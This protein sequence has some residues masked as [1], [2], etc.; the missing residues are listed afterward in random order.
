VARDVPARIK[1]AWLPQLGI[2]VFPRDLTQI[3][4]RLF[5]EG[6][7]VPVGEPFT[8][9]AATADD[10]LNA[11]VEAIAGIVALK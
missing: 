7:A 5:A 11:V 10:E 3:H 8:A 1:N 2:T 9:S 6:R 4:R